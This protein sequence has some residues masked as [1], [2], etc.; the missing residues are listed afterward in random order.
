M[1]ISQNLL[2]CPKFTCANATHFPRNHTDLMIF[3]ILASISA[4]LWSILSAIFFATLAVILFAGT[5]I[6]SAT[7]SSRF[8]S[9]RKFEVVALSIPLVGIFLLNQIVIIDISGT[10]FTSSEFI[11]VSGIQ[12][13]WVANSS[14]LVL[15][16]FLPLGNLL[17]LSTNAAIALAVS[18][19]IAIILSAIDVIHA[20]AAPNLALKLDA[21]PGRISLATLTS[22]FGGNFHGQCSELCG[23]LH[24]FMPLDFLLV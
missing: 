1:P 9:S 14:D 5:K 12:W 2:K 18:S 4:T 15:E 3:T 20:I 8:S 17:A 24:G 21:I 22:D 10:A 13:Y 19:Q 11:S 16:T 23:A 7:A 6:S